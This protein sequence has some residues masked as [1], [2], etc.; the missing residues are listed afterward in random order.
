MRRIVLTLEYM[1][2]EFSGFQTQPGKRTVQGEIERALFE[3]LGRKTKVFASGRTDAGVHALGLV[4]HFDTDKAWQVEK[5]SDQLNLIL[6]KDISV[7][8]IR[9]AEEGFDARYDCKEKTYGLRFYLSKHE[10]PFFQNRSL[11][12]NDNVDVNAM[13]ESCKFFIGKHDF[14]A[15]VARKSGKSDFERE[16]YSCFIHKINDEEFEFVVSGSGFLYNMVRIMFGT[17]LSAGTGKIK[18]SDIINIINS[19]KRGNAGMTVAPHGLYL[20]DVKY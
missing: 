4:L 17:V 3:I 5:F 9:D 19:R 13:M 2:S 8:R 1:G 16:I 14:T 15:F 12:V 20:L 10:R 6:P 7:V 18:P 11:R